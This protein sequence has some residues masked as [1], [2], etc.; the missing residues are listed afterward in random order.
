M[1]AAANPLFFPPT[2]FVISQKRQLRRVL[3]KL[4]TTVKAVLSV[5]IKNRSVDMRPASVFKLNGQC[6]Q[7]GSNVNIIV[8]LVNIFVMDLCDFSGKKI[9]ICVVCNI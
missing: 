9:S 5:H 2:L 8:G 6:V 7:Q 1:H 4:E 3:L